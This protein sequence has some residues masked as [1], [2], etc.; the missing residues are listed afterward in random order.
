MAYVAYTDHCT[1]R[2]TFRQPVAATHFCNCNYITQ[3][4]HTPHQKRVTFSQVLSPSARTWLPSTAACAEHAVILQEF[5][6]PWRA[7]ASLAPPMGLTQLSVHA[8][9]CSRGVTCQHA[10]HTPISS[11]LLPLRCGWA[12]WPSD[13]PAPVR[14]IAMRYERRRRPH[15]VCQCRSRRLP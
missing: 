13:C 14:I 5:G 11:D 2:P 7:P 3:T 12:I 1:H 8:C 4:Q 9:S 15:A 6:L 10:D